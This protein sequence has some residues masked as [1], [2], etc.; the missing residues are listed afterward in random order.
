MGIGLTWGQPWGRAKWRCRF[1][2][3]SDGKTA[4]SLKQIAMWLGVGS[5]N[6]HHASWKGGLLSWWV[7]WRWIS[8]EEFFCQLVGYGGWNV[9]LKGQLF[10]GSTSETIF[11]KKTQKYT[12]YDLKIE[13]LE[14]QERI[15]G[16]TVPT[17]TGVQQ[18]S[19]TTLRVSRIPML[20]PQAGDQLL[21]DTPPPTPVGGSPGWNW[22]ELGAEPGLGD[23]KCKKKKIQRHNGG[24]W[25]PRQSLGMG[26]G[27]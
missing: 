13:R 5:T 18:P 1:V 14:K 11:F 9:W 25:E 8:S 15:G 20:H 3:L 22:V 21:A 24:K 16:G 7:H 26:A 10:Q 12:E 6:L 19:T 4:F 23:Q 27:R 2:H 17:T